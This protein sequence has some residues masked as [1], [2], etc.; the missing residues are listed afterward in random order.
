MDTEGAPL[1]EG[2]PDPWE[3][4]DG[5]QAEALALASPLLLPYE[6]QLI[7][8]CIQDDS[9]IITAAGL[10]WQ[11]VVAVLLRIAQ[12]ARIAERQLICSELARH[13]PALPPPLDITNEVPAAERL[14]LYGG[15]GAPG[16]PLFITPRILVVDLLARRVRAHQMAGLLLLNAHRATDTSGEGFAVEKVMKALQEQVRQCLDTHKPVV[17]EWEQELSGPMVLIQ[18]ALLEVLEGLIRELKR[19]NKS[20]D[21]SELVLEAGVLK[22]FDEIVRRQLD[23]IWHTVGWKTRRICTDLRTLREL[24]AVLLA[25]DPVTFLAHLEG[26]RQSEG[27]RCVWLFHDATHAVFEQARRRVYVYRQPGGRAVLQQLYESYLALLAEAQRGGGSGTGA[28]G[29]AEQ[30][31]PGSRAGAAA[32]PASDS[33]ACPLLSDVHFVALDAHDEFVLWRLRPGVIIMYEP[34]LAFLRQGALNADLWLDVYS[35]NALTRTAG[36]RSMQAAAG[37]GP[38]RAGGPQLVVER[39]SLPDLTASLASGRLYHQAEVMCRHYARPLLLIEF[40]PD[41]Q[42]GLQSPAEL[43]D[44]IDPKNIISKLTLLTTHFPKLRLL[45]SR[46]PHATADLFAALKSN[47]DQPDAAAAAL[48]GVPLGPD[49]APLPIGAPG[50][51]NYRALLGHIPSLAALAD[52]PLARLEAVMGSA[53]NAR[54]LREFLDA[55]C[56]RL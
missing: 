40:D 28:Y 38:V 33:R 43:G 12:R 22:S 5:G 11:R 51:S 55:P 8:E 53:K 52:T 48:V 56:P 34:D 44:D 15:G 26:L 42:F 16:R 25:V 41:R 13:D 47:Q 6:R 23:P 1:D 20:L 21:T 14:A 2:A 37:A 45:W 31:A 27:V 19:T 3:G 7:E 46:S 4:A 30:G 39:K 9:L 49:G 24:S 36:G 35:A 54:A 18:A 29:T 32:A 50:D 10:G 17:V